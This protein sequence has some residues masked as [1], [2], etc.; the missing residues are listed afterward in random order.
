MTYS[1]CSRGGAFV[2]RHFLARTLLHGAELIEEASLLRREAFWKLHAHPHDEITSAWTAQLRHTLP[3]EADRKS[4][5]RAAGSGS[6]RP[7][8]MSR[9]RDIA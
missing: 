4:A 9:P 6:P 2:G 8:N 5:F 1:N 3:G 7:G